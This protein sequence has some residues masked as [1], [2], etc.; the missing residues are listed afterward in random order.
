MEHERQEEAG[1]KGE[2]VPSFLCA[3]SLGEKR[4]SQQDKKVTAV[5]SDVCT[6]LS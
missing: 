2:R 5:T 1:R 6:S 3:L 4:G